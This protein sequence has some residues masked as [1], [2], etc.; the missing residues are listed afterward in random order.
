MCTYKQTPTHIYTHIQKAYFR[1]F[2]SS[3]SFSIL[4]S[5]AAWRL[6]FILSNFFLRC[7][8]LSAFLSKPNEY[9]RLTR[10]T[11]VYICVCVYVFV[12]VYV[13]MFVCMILTFSS[14][15]TASSQNQ[16]RI[17]RMSYS[18]RP[19]NTHTH[20]HTYTYMYMYMCTFV[21]TYTETIT[22]MYVCL[23]AADLFLEFFS[24]DAW[25]THTYM[26]M[27]A[28]IYTYTHT[29]RHTDRKIRICLYISYCSRPF[30]RITLFFECLLL[31]LHLD[32]L[33]TR[34]WIVLCDSCGLS[35][36]FGHA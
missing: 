26:Y 10:C 2:S 8:S 35:T 16:A 3:L 15:M 24:L 4:T 14:R 32:T 13:C 9:W 1:S 36:G 29:N 21:H 31:L 20:T 23:T 5:L 30:P 25:I 27:Y 6:A 22:D 11:C 18:S 17:S 33:V 19:N 28:C 7:T 12:C 34:P